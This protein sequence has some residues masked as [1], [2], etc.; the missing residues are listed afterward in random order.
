MSA[1]IVSLPGV[2]V[3]RL[4]R[5]QSA[6]TEAGTLGTALG[7][8]AAEAVGLG[9]GVPEGVGGAT[10]ATGDGDGVAA[11]LQPA[12]IRA[13]PSTATRDTNLMISSS[14]PAPDRTKC[15]GRPMNPRSR[16]ESRNGAWRREGAVSRE[17][18]RRDGRRENAPATDVFE[19]R[20]DQVLGGRPSNSP[21]RP[22][23][24]SSRR[25]SSWLISVRFHV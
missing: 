11:A 2:I 1:P 24:R 12:M 7:L 6:P 25:K 14:K 16:R 20:S 10:D 8:A 9:T 4:G 17:G 15:S 13:T 21:N 22:V 3:L 18:D 5:E 23:C 19:L